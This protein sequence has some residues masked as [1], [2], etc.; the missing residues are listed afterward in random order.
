MLV[1]ISNQVKLVAFIN[2]RRLEIKRK[3]GLEELESKQKYIY[4][5]SHIVS[6]L[7]PRCP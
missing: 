1:S 7:P 3:G 2:Y 6:K 4:F 5:Y